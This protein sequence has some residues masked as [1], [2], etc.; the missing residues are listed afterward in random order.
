MPEPA[1]TQK[2]ALS[3]TLG[4]GG[5]LIAPAGA[6]PGFIAD[7]FAASARA[8][9]RMLQALAPL[10]LPNDAQMT[11]SV[12]R[13]AA[14]AS[15]AITVDGGAV[16]STDITSALASAPVGL[17]AGQQD[18]S[19]QL[20]DRFGGIP[21]QAHSLSL[22][23]A[24]AVELGRAMGQQ[25]DI[26]I[27]NGSGAAGHLKGLL[28]TSGIVARTYTDASPTPAK[29]FSAVMG[30]Y[31]DQ[32]AALGDTP[33]VCLFAPRRLAQ[34][35]SSYA[36]TNRAAFDRLGIDV[37]A[38]PSMPLTLG[39]GTNEDRVIMIDSDE[40]LLYIDQPVI[41]VHNDV[42]SGNMQVRFQVT[43]YASVMAARQPTATAVL[44]GTG[45]RRRVSA[46]D[47]VV[48]G[49]SEFSSL[50]GCRRHAGLLNRGGSAWRTFPVCWRLPAAVMLTPMAGATQTAVIERG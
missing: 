37:L 34:L 30:L 19:Q 26:E 4:A 38:I 42:L 21:R 50:V 11:L 24:F 13:F 33:D 29:V 9:S 45:L 16:S 6:V 44:S 32:A 46:S 1:P 2:R 14:G 40:V 3:T 39:S 36:S 8:E 27:L 31:S 47:Q 25:L 15:A 28:T 48:V 7:A 20:L 22:D 18:V 49:V 17:I 23:E 10:P 43:Q 35:E 12:P 5:D 41:K